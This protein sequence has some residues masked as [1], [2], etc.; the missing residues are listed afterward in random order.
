MF[1]KGRFIVVR[2]PPTLPR[3][4]DWQEYLD[5]YGQV[6][7]SCTVRSDILSTS[8]NLRPEHLA[9]RSMRCS[10]VYDP[11]IADVVEA[12]TITPQSSRLKL[13]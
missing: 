8:I 4:I 13:R 10:R 3:H 1:G 11:A 9:I 5:T 7:D 2:L 12:A 6:V